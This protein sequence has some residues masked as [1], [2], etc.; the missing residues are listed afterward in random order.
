MSFNGQQ[1]QVQRSNIVM[2]V[3]LVSHELCVRMRW[4]RL[5]LA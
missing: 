5:Q 3:Q 1:R 4:R 2:G